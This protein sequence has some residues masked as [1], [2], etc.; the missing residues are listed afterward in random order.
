LLWVAPKGISCSIALGFAE[1]G[2]NI[3][4]ATRGPGALEATQRDIEA[5]GH[6]CIALSA[7]MGREAERE[8]I[9]NESASEFLGC[10][11]AWCLLPEVATIG[12][13]IRADLGAKPFA[14]TARGPI[15]VQHQRIA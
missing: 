8:R 12:H 14:C 15:V 13:V 9:A 1:Q 3:S 7:H 10:H 6:R 5:V 4:I 2:P 11:Q